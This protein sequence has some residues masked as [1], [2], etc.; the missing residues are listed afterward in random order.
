MFYDLGKKKAWHIVK[1]DVLYMKDL[2]NDF[3]Y[4]HDILPNENN[5]FHI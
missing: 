5:T 2:Q 3:A 1:Y 4:I